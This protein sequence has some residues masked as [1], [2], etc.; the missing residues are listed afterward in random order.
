[1]CLN[2]STRNK[3][4]NPET[5]TTKKGKSYRTIQWGAHYSDKNGAWQCV[6]TAYTRYATILVKEDSAITVF[7]T[8]KNC[9]RPDQEYTVH[10]YTSLVIFLLRFL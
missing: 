6:I 4:Y 2:I 5:M 3:K 8:C 1:V 10:K 9:G 7:W